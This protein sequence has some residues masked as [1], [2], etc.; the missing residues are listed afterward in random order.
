MEAALGEDF[1][2]LKKS[3]LRRALHPEFEGQ[4]DNKYRA[5]QQ[6]GLKMM[7]TFAWDAEKSEATFWM[8]REV[9]DEMQR[10]REWHVGMWRT[11]TWDNVSWPWPVWMKGI[12]KRGSRWFG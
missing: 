8:D 2:L 10:S 6:D 9:M 3:P 11:D 7:T 4:Y 12:I 1:L 5:L